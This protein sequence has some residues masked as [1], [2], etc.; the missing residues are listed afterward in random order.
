MLTPE[1]KK[2]INRNKD[3]KPVWLVTSD[4]ILSILPHNC[5]KKEVKFKKKSLKKGESNS[6]RNKSS[7]KP[8]ILAR[9]CDL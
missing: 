3:L 6:S 5:L 9:K 8:F 2:T 7:G 1:A 4:S